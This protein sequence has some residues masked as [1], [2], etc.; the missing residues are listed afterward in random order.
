M[1]TIKGQAV[2][3]TTYQPLPY[4]SVQVVDDEGNTTGEGV[5]ADAD[6]RFELTTNGGWVV[7]TYAGFD[8]AL[9]ATADIAN[10]D[11]TSVTVYPAGM[12]PVTVTATVHKKTN[13]WVWAIAAAAAYYALK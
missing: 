6:G 2:N 4:A 9:V 5:V 10:S 1:I 8:P 12:S 11:Y 13:V 3:G 7:V